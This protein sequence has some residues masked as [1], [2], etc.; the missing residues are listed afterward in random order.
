MAALPEVPSLGKVLVIGGCG[1]LGSHIVSLI[2]KR[3]PQ[4]QIAVLD[5]RTNLNRNASP[6]VSYHDCDI[7]N[8]DAV[9]SVFATVKPDVVIHTASPHFNAKSEIHNKVN[10]EGTKIL[11]KAAQD[12]KVKAFVYTSSASVVLDPTRELVNADETW[13]LVMG[14]RQ[15]EYYTTTKAYAEIAV[16]EANRTPSDFLT[17]AIRPAGIFGEGDVQLL[18]KMVTAFRKGQTKFQVGQNNNLFDFTYVE[19]IAHGHLLAAQ[20]LLHTH[21]ILPTVPL[22][23]ERVDGEAFFITN[24]QPVYFWDFARA[25]W[26]EAGDRLPLSS[27]WHLSDDVAWAIGTLLESVFW[28]LG[29]TPNLTRA[30]VRYS[31][32][33]KYHSIEKARRRLGFAPVVGLD[34]GIRRGVG[35]IL[36]QEEK[37][38]QKKGQ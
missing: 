5:L 15:P 10:V 22:D 14:D 27:V 38:K 8:L 11:L 24:G 35:Y 1:F 18:P 2:V 16:L 3:H 33:T 29:K 31:T 23:S 17:C 30:Q 13:P 21:S 20:A 32:M 36:E 12:S 34:E 26:H 19:N 9:Q 37:E 7:T 6:I 28:V 25:V 4:S